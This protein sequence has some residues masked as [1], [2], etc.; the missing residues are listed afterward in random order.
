MSA[1]KPKGVEWLPGVVGVLPAG[2]CLN[3]ACFNHD[4]CYFSRCAGGLLC[5]FSPQTDAVGCDDPL[6]VTACDPGSSGCL[7]ADGILWYFSNKTICMV[8]EGYVV[9]QTI[10]PLCQAR[11]CS[12][13]GEVCNPT[14]SDCCVAT[15][16]ICDGIDNDC[17]GTVDEECPSLC[18]ADDFNRADSLTV[19]D[20]WTELYSEG[21]QGTERDDTNDDACVIESQRLRLQAGRTHGTVPIIYRPCVAAGGQSISFRFQRARQWLRGEMRNLWAQLRWNGHADP[22]TSVALRIEPNGA[23]LSLLK[24]VNGVPVAIESGTV[25]AIGPEIDYW[26]WLDIV[27]N[28][29]TWDLRGFF[30]DGP[31]KPLA[32]T[33]VLTTVDLSDVSGTSA[34]IFGDSFLDD[35]SGTQNYYLIDDIRITASP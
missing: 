31:D 28:G 30:S 19:G 33:V 6:V 12:D 26:V 34:G 18:A 4:S 16:E 11:P 17:D 23:G 2:P 7:Q 14:T 5:I 25:A 32:P 8:A 21:G 27:P 9:A 10:N 15:V 20:G 29:A 24:M 13:P 22:N 35:P 1:N 3:R